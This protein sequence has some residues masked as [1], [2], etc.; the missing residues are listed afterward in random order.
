[1]VTPHPLNSATRSA[2]TTYPAL[3]SEY[4]SHVLQ[5][6]RQLSRA[7]KYNK[8]DRFGGLFYCNIKTTGTAG[9]FYVKISLSS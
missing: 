3:P 1:V 9:G 7:K 6:L 4:R 2:L 8:K 5:Q